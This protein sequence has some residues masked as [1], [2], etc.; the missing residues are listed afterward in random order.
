MTKDQLTR[1]KAEVRRECKGEITE[2]KLA[3][4][5]ANY[6]NSGKM[7]TVYIEPNA[8]IVTQAMIGDRAIIRYKPDGKIDA[9]LSAMAF[10]MVN[11]RGMTF[12]FRGR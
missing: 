5:I 11:D 10:I 6:N 12:T 4:C 7:L 1:F 3:S 8:V 9:M 2:A